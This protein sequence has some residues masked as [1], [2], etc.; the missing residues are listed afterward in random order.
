MDN[1]LLGKLILP[2]AGE[3]HLP[4]LLSSA[5]ALTAA[6][7]I[8]LQI[9]HHSGTRRKVI[10]FAPEQRSD[11]VRNGDRIQSGMVIGFRAER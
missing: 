9:D 7:S 3:A 8:P 11:S 6:E 5:A 2:F 1:L 10:G 4:V